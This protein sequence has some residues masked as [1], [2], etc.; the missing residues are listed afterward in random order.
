MKKLL[1]YLLILITLFNLT[2]CSG[3]DAEELGKNVT[4]T[5]VTERISDN[6]FVAS[7]T[8]FAIKLLQHTA[9]ENP[10]ENLLVSPLSVMLALSMTAN[11]ADSETR[12]EMEKILT[13]GFSL[14][15]LNEYLYTYVNTL[16]SSKD[17]KLHIANSIWM[18]NDE[19]FVVNEKFLET[20]ASY[21][22]AQIYQADFDSKTVRDINRWVEKNTDGMIDQIIEEIPEDTLMYL[23]NALSFDAEWDNIYEKF[24]IHDADFVSIDRKKNTVD[25]M[26][27]SEWL[28]LEDTYATGFIKDYKD[29]RYQFAALLPNE[30]IDLYDYIQSLNSEALIQTLQNAEN[31]V[32]QAALPKFSYEFYTSLKDTLSTMGIQAAF[33]VNSADFSRLGSYPDRNIFI[34][35]VIHKTCISVDVKGTKAGAATSIAMVEGSANPADM[36]KV[37][38]NRPFVYM[39]IES[40]SKLPL[41]I[42]TVTEINK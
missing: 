35:D 39:I 18:R 3:I 28:Y 38:L 40:G 6:S 15:M 17:S 41:F 31:T 1:C 26:Y 14:E 27:S 13:G 11:G 36:K 25:M 30:G 7:Q 37:Y 32:V 42:G 22:D 21:F 8:D 34:S 5:P 23:I 29:G 33:D 4:K 2:A 12:N 10:N 24:Q 16:P 9:S 19:N 20:N